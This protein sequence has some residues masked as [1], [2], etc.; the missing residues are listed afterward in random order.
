MSWAKTDSVSLSL[1]SARS[2]THGLADARQVLYHWAT[3]SVWK[4]LV[5]KENIFLVTEI[6]TPTEYKL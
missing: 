3:S 2:W 6:K 5:L 4:P 1:S